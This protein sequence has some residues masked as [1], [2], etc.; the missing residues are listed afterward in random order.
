MATA[1]MTG[2]VNLMN[3][4]DPQTPF[5][6]IKDLLATADVRFSN[7]EC[8]LHLPE[9]GHA[10]EH[11]GFFADPEIGAGAL[12]DADI[13]V[14]GIANN[15][16]YGE[17]NIVGSMLTLKRHGVLFAGAG[18]NLAEARKPVIVQRAGVRY[19]FLQRS[20]VYWS[21]NH[22]AGETGVGIAV[23][24]GNTAYHVPMYRE[25]LRLPPFNRPGIPPLIV[26]W[27]DK[28]YLARFVD[29]VQALRRDVDVV[30]ASCHWGLGAEVL[31]YMSDIAHAAIDAGADVVMGHGP[32]RPLPVGFHKG[33]PIFYGLG[34]FSFH[35]GHLGIKHG[36]WIGLLVKMT[37]GAKTGALGFSFSFV[38]HNDANETSPCTIAEEKG[39]LEI[40]IAASRKH[41]AELQVLGEN[42]VITAIGDD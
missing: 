32:H 18:Y 11:E 10:I 41:G 33:K 39:P 26:T 8:A 7:L 19:G 34:S 6:R 2:D 4:E 27:A 35:T 30:I 16:N 5:R 38:R 9:H 25:D 23:I 24:R 40:Q 13:D 3:V 12:R 29:D 22:E 17:A 28:D 36:D 20:S 37:G 1:F 31:T 42:V 15:V 21:T 14:V